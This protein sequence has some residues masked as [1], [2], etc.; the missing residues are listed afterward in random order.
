L[1]A[2]K[3]RPQE[4]TQPRSAKAQSGSGFEQS[5]QAAENAGRGLDSTAQ[6]LHHF[7]AHRRPA[8]KIPL[9]ASFYLSRCDE[10]S[11]FG[12]RNTFIKGKIA[13]MPKIKSKAVFK[14]KQNASA[15]NATATVKLLKRQV[16]RLLRSE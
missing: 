6:N 15:A 12:T 16:Q 11:L 10:W 2:S 14:A 3:F 4:G 1:C 7:V 5:L 9:G 8:G 13:P